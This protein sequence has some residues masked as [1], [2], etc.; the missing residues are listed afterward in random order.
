VCSFNK[1]Q[2]TTWGNRSQLTSDIVYCVISPI[3][4]CLN[5]NH[6]LNPGSRT[7][8][9]KI[10]G[11]VYTILGTILILTF[12]T[13]CAGDSDHGKRHTR[14]AIP[15]K[16]LVTATSRLNSHTPEMID[17]ETRLDSVLLSDEGH[18]TYY[19]TIIGREAGTFS[20]DAFNA[21]IYPRIINNI[22]ANPD[23]KMHRDSGV[24][25][26]FYYRD[27]NGEPVTEISIGPDRYR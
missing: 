22:H 19:Y 10:T 5:A 2:Y 6:Y 3:L 23:L 4:G 17:A 20:E 26:D 15:E 11:F 24:V 12:Q 13:G 1:I 27:R 8:S 7:G 16:N 18:L 14:R 21:Y 25:M 9:M